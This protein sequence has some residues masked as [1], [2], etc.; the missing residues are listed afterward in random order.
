MGRRLEIRAAAIFILSL[1]VLLSIHA[2]A[3]DARIA[4]I[5]SSDST[6]PYVKNLA[7]LRVIV[8]GRYYARCPQWSFDRKIRIVPEKRMIDNPDEINA[9]LSDERLGI[10]S[11]YQFYS[12]REKFDS[13]RSS[14]KVTVLDDRPRNP[15]PKTIEEFND[16]VTP[17][18]PNTIEE[19]ARLDGYAAVTQAKEI[20]KQP[21]GTAI[22]FGVDFDLNKDRQ[23]NVI[24]YFR[25]IKK[26]VTDA[27]Y[28]M[29]VYG[30]GAIG[31]LLRGENPSGEKL[32][33]YVWLT[34]SPAHAGSARTYNVKHWDLLQTRTDTAW[35]ISG[36]KV[37]LDTNIQNPESTDV[38]F[39][40]KAASS[41]VSHDRNVAVQSA[42][43]FV[44]EGRPAVVDDQGKPITAKACTTTFGI[45]VRM[46]E[47]NASKTLVRVDCDEDGNADGW[48]KVKDL[49]AKRPL[50]ANDRERATTHCTNQ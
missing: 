7:A 36:K 26:L 34:A 23:E 30:N 50:W 35:A 24:T 43:R 28:V 11:V 39:W 40:N 17:D 6:K 4:I 33:E 1:G 31:D 8:V 32:V 21:P 47:M 45:V 13:N 18:K 22:Y 29:G 44:C 20:M 15:N 42:R 2:Q 16:C 38:G 46:F 48:M 27:G 3:Q 9:I 25:I 49:S 19:D 37:E 41:V 10:L 14:G 12:Q 5:D